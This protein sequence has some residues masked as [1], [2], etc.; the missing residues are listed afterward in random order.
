M[1]S[2]G[3]IPQ[4]P[5]PGYEKNNTTHIDW[6]IEPWRRRET[7]IIIDQCCRSFREFLVKIDENDFRVKGCC[8]LLFVIC[9]LFVC[10]LLVVVCCLLFV[11]YLFVVCWLLFFCWLLFVVCCVLFVVCCLWLIVVD[12]CVVV[13]C[14]WSLSL[15]SSLLFCRC[16]CCCCRCCCRFFQKGWVVLVFGKLQPN[17]SSPGFGK[18]V[19]VTY[20]IVS[21]PCFYY[22][23]CST[24]RLDMPDFLQALRELV[25]LF[26]EFSFHMISLPLILIMSPLTPLK[27]TSKVI[28]SLENIRNPHDPIKEHVTKSHS[29]GQTPLT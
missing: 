24:P 21:D 13:C 2:L 17:G 9:C 26:G 28:V 25:R 27:Y 11:V 1:V 10:C 3:L 23:S 22:G 18:V 19:L 6:G 20:C 4:A 15:L 7:W 12:S 5:P 16:R 8:L 14:W 29:L